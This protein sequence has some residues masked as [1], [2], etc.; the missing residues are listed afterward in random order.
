MMQTHVLKTN[1]RR[2]EISL[3]LMR[4]KRTGGRKRERGRG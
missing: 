3:A 2:L 4:R 1:L